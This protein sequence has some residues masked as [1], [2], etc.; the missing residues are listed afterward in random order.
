MKFVLFLKKN[1]KLTRKKTVLMYRKRTWCVVLM[2]LVVMSSL[3]AQS[4]QYAVCQEAGGTLQLCNNLILNNVANAGTNVSTLPAN[5][6]AG[7]ITDVFIDNHLDFSIK[8]GASAVNTGDNSCERW[9]F[10][11]RREKRTRQNTVD[12][13]AFE[14]YFH[15]E[16]TSYVMCQEAIG[17]LQLCNNLI[18]NNGIDNLMNVSTLP[19]NNIT[20]EDTLIFTDN[21]LDFSIKPGSVAMNA[22]DN[23]CEGWSFDMRREK[24]AQQN[25]VDVG[26]FEVYFNH[27]DTSYI[28]C[29]ELAGSLQ[30]CNNLILNNGID[31]LMNVST[32]SASNIVG[33]DTLVFTDN[34]LDFSI[35]PG[36][37]AVNAG[38]N[39][40]VIWG[41]DLRR[42]KR[43]QQNTV[44]VGAFELYSAREA[45]I[46]FQE[47]AGLLSLC[48]NLILNNEIIPVTNVPVLSENNITGEDTSIFVDN[49]LDFSL[50]E[51]AVAVNAGDN[52]CVSWELDI[53]GYNRI[54]CHTVDIGAYEVVS[55]E[56]DATLIVA[57]ICT[58]ESYYFNGDTL[59]MSGEY[60][61]ILESSNG[62]DSVVMLR[63]TV[64]EPLQAT[65]IA[66]DD[67]I[68][69]G[70]EVIL[71]TVVHDASAY[72][73]PPPPP[74][75]GVGDI[76]C[77]DGATVKASE[78]A[79]SGKT[80]M[81]VV[82]YVDNT[83][84]HGWAVHLNDQ[85]NQIKWG[86]YGVDI[87]YLTNVSGSRAAVLDMD[88]YTNTLSIRYYNGSSAYPAAW[89]VD[90]GNGW[91]LPACG[92]L[93]ILY[94][95]RVTVNNSINIVDGTPMPDNSSTWRYWSST[96]ATAN[97]AYLI[98]SFGA[99]S[100]YSKNYDA[101]NVRSIRSF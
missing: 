101:V 67:T 96:E 50:Q 98:E 2:L 61:Q 88:G 26:A 93:K 47:D 51:G 39:D 20:G 23:S 95:E 66:T 81:G 90:F 3:R 64:V 43:V 28:M 62:C 87:P 41:R 79:A 1:N 44:D 65:I 69:A 78:Y 40:C 48:N 74:A 22:G 46:V 29:Q 86:G 36:S 9:N 49:A 75:V 82:F 53:S 59:T 72:V 91:F 85:G 13:G 18:L 11:L 12:V 71:G 7:E 4:L 68:C 58:G 94:A 24:R 57:T 19:A 92:Q 15:H 30:L 83:G 52:A 45:F 14:V 55:I 34:H 80:A 38:D 84:E 63:L 60:T 17:N 16:D 42:E 33:E 32:L 76:L 6:I 97:S 35:K 27:E 5:N 10:D 73:T 8:P 89:T 56:P 21:H 100:S 37:V 54:V 25:A 99:I 77:T 70:E 31:N